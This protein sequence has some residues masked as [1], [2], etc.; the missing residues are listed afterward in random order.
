MAIGGSEG[1]MAG[2]QQT[3]DGGYIASGWTKSY[4]AGDWDVYLIKLGPDLAGDLDLDGDVDMV[5]FSLFTP[6][7]AAD[8]TNGHWDPGCDL[9]NP[10]DNTIDMRDLA[11]LI[12]NWLAGGWRSSSRECSYL[13][14]AMR[15]KSTSSQTPNRFSSFSKSRRRKRGNNRT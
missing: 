11:V 9:S 15:L 7:W 5:D 10:A 3:P 2:V 12:E 6:G 1:E 4:G 14:G 13:A 8:S